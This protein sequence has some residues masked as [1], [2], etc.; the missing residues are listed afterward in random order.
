MWDS[1]VWA[2]RRGVCEET[3]EK[4]EEK[5][6][7]LNRNKS[8]RAQCAHENISQERTFLPVS[9]FLSTGEVQGHRREEERFTQK[10]QERGGLRTHI[11]QHNGGC[12]NAPSGLISLRVSII[13]KFCMRVKM[14]WWTREA[15]R[16]HN[17]ADTEQTLTACGDA[18]RDASVGFPM[19]RESLLSPQIEFSVNSEDKVRKI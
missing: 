4:P 1:A 3:A 15:G 12:V 13:K 8:H 19:A 18:D 17:L 5:H 11:S 14:L 10:R 2:G 6:V 16:F 9:H 7:V